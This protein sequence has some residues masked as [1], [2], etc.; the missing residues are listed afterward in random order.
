[1]DKRKIIL[2]GAFDRYNF[3]DIL[4]PIILKKY[5]SNCKK[6]INFQFCSIRDADL[7]LYGGFSSTK[8]DLKIL[9]K[10]TAIIIAG[11]EV[12]NVDWSSICSYYYGWFI[13]RSIRVARLIL[14]RTII[15]YICCKHLN[16]FFSYPFLI[17]KMNISNPIKI[18]YNGVGGI[19]L[20]NT[21]KVIKSS[22][23]NATYLSVRDRNSNLL[24]KKKWD[25][26]NNITPDIATSVSKFYPKDKMIKKTTQ[27][28]RE[29]IENNKNNYFCFQVAQH[30]TIG[31]LHL[32]TNSLSKLLSQG[33]NIALLPLGIVSG[34]DDDK[35]LQKIYSILDSNQVF[36]LKKINIINT[37]SL[38]A[39]CSVFAG[40]SLHGNITAISYSVPHFPLNKQVPK[41]NEYI[42]EWD[43]AETSSCDDYSKIH[44][45]YFNAIK[46]DI[47]LLKRNKD[48]LITKVDENILEIFKM[49]S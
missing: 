25:I 2:Y 27:E 46:I 32:I 39:N 11:G 6:N 5:I 35:I 12:L 8:L 26:R 47:N 41:L 49:I 44:D 42:K 33:V 16:G 45:F 24:L 4:M 30:Y 17:E 31:K 15:N 20:K 34:H 29:F 38:I 40:T 9:S 1:M 23:Q 48:K 3:G 36:L 7:S 14:P 37:L 19:S 10:S 13:N 28:T 43:I 18:I 22:L 21:D